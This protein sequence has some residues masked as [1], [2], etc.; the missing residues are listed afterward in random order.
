MSTKA[1]TDTIN[2]SIAAK[3]I[4]KRSTKP[5]RCRKHFKTRLVVHLIVINIH[6]YFSGSINMQLR[7]RR[8]LK[9]NDLILVQNAVHQ[10]ALMH[11]F[12]NIV[13]KEVIHLVRT[14]NFPKI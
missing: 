8:K 4:Q 11:K 13:C 1:K 14:Q 7:D 12:D 5:F 3:A 10:L 2:E 9:R 6:L